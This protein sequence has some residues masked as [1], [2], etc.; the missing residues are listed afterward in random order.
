MRAGQSVLITGASGGMGTAIVQLARLAG[1]SAIIATTGSPEKAQRLKEL[2]VDHVVNY[3]EAGATDRV[4]S[5]AQGKG[6]DL[7]VDLVGGEMFIFG[8][9]CLRMNGTI[10]LV[11]GEEAEGSIPL[12]TLSVMLLHTHV[13]ILGVRG[14]RR[15]DNKTV[16]DLLGQGK[17]DPVIDK[18][19][20]LSEAAK[21]HEMLESREQIGKIILVP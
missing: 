1:A 20:P 15:I 14:A 9:K 18:V 17:I 6:V 11:A 10:V 3:R 19:L 2:G 12:K 5:L 7:V 13:N 4:K 21:A 8:M 16:L